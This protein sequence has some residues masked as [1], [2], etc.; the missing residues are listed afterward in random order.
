MKYRPRT[1]IVMSPGFPSDEAD[2]V[3]LPAQQLFV[4][5]LNRNFP[6][7]R[8]IIISFEYPHRRDRYPWFGNTVIAV[9]GWKKGR[10]N[11]LRTCLTVWK[12]LYALQ[13]EN[14]VIGLLSFWIG[15]CALV[16]KYYARRHRLKH[17]TWILGQDARKGN[18]F[19]RLVR[20]AG[21]ELVA[22]SNFLAAELD[23]NYHISPRHIIPNG[24][25]PSLYGPAAAVRD[26]DVLGVGSLIP[27]K[28]Y[29][30]FISAV[31][32][33]AALLPGLRSM[34]CGKG[35]ERS[36]LQQMIGQLGLHGNVVLAGETTHQET[37]A[38]MQRAKI[39]LHTS[40]YEGFSTVCLE[41]LY[42]G[43][44][45]ISFTD[46][47]GSPVKNW[48]VVADMTAMMD[49]ALSLLQDPH[50]KYEPVRLYTMEDSAREM[51]ALY[52]YRDDAIL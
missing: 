44:H 2:T 51:M 16:G 6:D 3:C 4:S 45:V 5:A 18:K 46:P 10:L 14:E 28:Q 38:I 48:H 32:W 13:R 19:I 52:D 15:G 34:I 49:R 11:K 12:I 40:S 30:L 37:I 27:L 50:T 23:R 42:A 41:A 21:T 25:D 47:M 43:A 7:L 17:L 24:V 9:G 29:D 8:V 31:H 20:P 26:I 35:P 22:M 33:L 36:H 39:L 1:L